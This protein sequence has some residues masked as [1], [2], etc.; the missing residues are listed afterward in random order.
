MHTPDELFSSHTPANGLVKGESQPLSHAKRRVRRCWLGCSHL[1][2]KSLCNNAA[3][4]A[5]LLS[6]DRLHHSFARC[7][8][9]MGR[10]SWRAARQKRQVNVTFLIV[11]KFILV[12]YILKLHINEQERPHHSDSTASRSLC[13]VKHCRAWLVLRWGTTLESRVLFFLTFFSSLAMVAR[14]A[15]K[16]RESAGV[17]FD[18]LFFASHG[19]QSSSK[20]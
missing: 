6:D 9:S 5:D 8:L 2:Q 3:A 4:A 7:L 12:L 13:E 18:F 20:E 14:V 16:S 11:V 10:C 1:T 17:L 19:C 15:A